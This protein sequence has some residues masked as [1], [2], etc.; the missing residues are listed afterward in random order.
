MSTLVLTLIGPDRA[1]LVEAVAATIAEHDG[2]WLGSRMSRLAG[3]FAGILEVEVPEEQLGALKIA[4]QGLARQGLRVVTEGSEAASAGAG[5]KILRLELVGQDRPGIVRE[6]SQVLARRGVN[7]E[8]LRTDRE[9]APMSGEALFRA[10]ARLRL[11][12][13]ADVEEL[14]STLESIAS[15]LMVDL[16]LIEAEPRGQ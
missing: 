4:L 12:D 11:P 5:D 1:G 6:I 15:D 14:R 3:Q 10:R 7:V 16:S 9:S 8:E 13:S 2:N